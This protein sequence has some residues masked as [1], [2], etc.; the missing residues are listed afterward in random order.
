MAEWMR[1]RSSRP[2]WPTCGSAC[3]VT[4][5]PTSPTG[6]AHLQAQD[7]SSGKWSLGA[8]LPG[9][10]EADVDQALA[11]GEILRTWP[12]RGTIHIVHPAN[13]HW[14][15]DLTG[16]RA[17]NGLQARWDYL[18]LDK[19][20]VER[21]AEVLGEAVQ[22]TRMTRSQC[23]TTLND[24]GIDTSGQR[25]YHLLWYASQIGVTCIGPNEGK[26]QTFVLLDEWAKDPRTPTRDE[27]LA[28]L[29]RMYFQSHGPASRADFQR[30][31][32]L[33]ATDSKKAI[34]GA[35]LE[36]V[37][38]D[39]QELLTV[40]AETADL[41][42]MML[43]PGFDEFMLGYKDRSLFMEPE[44]LRRVVPGMNG[45]FR[46]TVVER[47][48]VIGTWGRKVMATS[49]RLTVTGFDSLKPAQRKALTAPAE[50]YAAFL[51]TRLDLRFE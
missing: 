33:T 22:G 46:P 15:L 24:A 48:R 19:E 32:G 26:E 29:A 28:L 16:R 2:A 9:A 4:A 8:R 41:P 3:R 36:A 17:L 44:H 18:G 27:A 51:G 23:L 21:G 35:D 25:A 7:L 31:T 5:Q 40:P 50:Q 20:T 47:G 42:R 11:A 45:I 1:P 34:A 39:D 10:T 30:W 14:M 37:S 13:A 6:A 49:V 43:L 38:L 12:M